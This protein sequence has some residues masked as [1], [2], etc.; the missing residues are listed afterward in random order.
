VEHASSASAVDAVKDRSKAWA[1]M[2]FSI[3]CT[4]AAVELLAKPGT[5]VYAYFD[6]RLHASDADSVFAEW[7][8]GMWNANQP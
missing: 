8:F 1:F 7:I 2:C 6:A 5:K 4:H 3:V